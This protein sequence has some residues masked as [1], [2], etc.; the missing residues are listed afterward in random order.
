MLFLNKKLAKKSTKF[1]VFSC[2]KQLKKKCIFITLNHAIYYRETQPN[3]QARKQI[4]K[5][6]H[7]V[8]D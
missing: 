4:N 1:Q 8:L 5:T 3:K 6:L 2:R 7:F